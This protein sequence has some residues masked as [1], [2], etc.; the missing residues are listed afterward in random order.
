MFVALKPGKERDATA[1]Q[2]IARLRPKLARVIGA[3]LYL[4]AVQ[5]IRGGGRI[6]NA[7]YQYTLQADSL[8]D[9]SEWAP[10]M[11]QPL[12][13]LPQPR[14]PSSAQQAPGPHGPLPL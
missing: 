12:P 10:R 3:T 9:L 14:D 4:Q 7:Q 8:S 2:I 1:D 6:G 5:D 11:L 13:P